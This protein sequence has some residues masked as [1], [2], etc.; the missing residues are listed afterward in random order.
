MGI[1]S[2]GVISLMIHYI[3]AVIGSLIIGFIEILS[4]LIESVEMINILWDSISSMVEFAAIFNIFI[5][6]ASSRSSSWIS[7]R[8]P[9]PLDTFDDFASLRID[10]AKGVHLTILWSL[11]LTTYFDLIGWQLAGAHVLICRRMHHVLL[12]NC[13][14]DI[15]ILRVSNDDLIMSLMLTNIS[16]VLLSI[17]S[18][19]LKFACI[20]ASVLRIILL[21][22]LSRSGVPSSRSHLGMFDTASSALLRG[23]CLSILLDIMDV[24][25]W[26]F[27]RILELLRNYLSCNMY[28][29]SLWRRRKHVVW[30]FSRNALFGCHIFRGLPLESLIHLSR[31]CRIIL[32]LSRSSGIFLCC[33]LIFLSCHHLFKLIFV[34]LSEYA[35]SLFSFGYQI[36]WC[37]MIVKSILFDIRFAFFNINV[38]IFSEEIHN[39]CINWYWIL[40]KD[41]PFLLIRVNLVVPRMVANIFNGVS[42]WRVWVKYH[43]K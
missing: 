29:W 11:L 39:V 33:L 15:N 19:I 41:Y 5:K 16:R 35:S 34:L 38:I 14:S 27:D 25:L 6:A 4:C 24:L 31:R 43:L 20:I 36:I 26:C 30:L 13:W 22:I 3:D 7:R 1:H 42:P 12:V 23:P 8:L 2:C 17:L 37:C 32:R 40:A 21:L 28:L 10:S 9:L 18:H